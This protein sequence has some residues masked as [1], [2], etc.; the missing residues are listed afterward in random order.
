MKDCT[1]SCRLTRATRSS[2]IPLLLSCGS[3][4]TPPPS[5]PVGVK[6]ASLFAVVGFRPAFFV[7]F[8]P[9]RKQVVVSVMGTK[10]VSG[11]VTD[12]VVMPARI[13]SPRAGSHHRAEQF[14]G[15]ETVAAH[16]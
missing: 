15:D 7:A 16:K 6:N 5:P 3:P 13:P 8:D 14:V 10:S 11:V 12:L 9:A 4:S 2:M 1:S